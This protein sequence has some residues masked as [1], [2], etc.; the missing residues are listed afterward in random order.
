MLPAILV[1]LA[2]P[3]LAQEKPPE[4]QPRKKPA[5]KIQPAHE[6]PTPEQIRRFNELAKKRQ[7]PERK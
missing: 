1:L 3:G 7:V 6:A 4:K 2:V 5:A